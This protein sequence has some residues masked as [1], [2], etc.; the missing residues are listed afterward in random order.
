[1]K[2]KLLP[3]Q[4]LK[5]RKKQ[6]TTNISKKKLFFSNPLKIKGNPLYL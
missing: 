4:C 5:L 6:N 3:I 1:M 2:L